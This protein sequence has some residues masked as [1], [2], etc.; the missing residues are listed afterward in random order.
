MASLMLI[1]PRKRKSPARRKVRRNPA[2]AVKKAAPKTN[3]M[4]RYKSRVSARRARR[5]PIG[6]GGIQRTLMDS[7]IGGAGAVGVDFIV[8]MLPLPYSMKSGWTGVATKA[9]LAV[10]VGMLGKKILGR[11]AEKMAEG[12]LTVLAYSSIKGL[13]PTSINT[14]ASVN[15]LGYMSPAQNAGNMAQLSEYLNPDPYAGSANL[16]GLGEYVSY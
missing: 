9:A 3:P 8:D 1:N 12:A 13:M 15:G 2:T 5:N 10:G 6:M 16:S 7:V 4:R 14:G 11:N